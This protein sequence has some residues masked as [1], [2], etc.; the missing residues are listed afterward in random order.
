MRRTSCLRSTPSSTHWSSDEAAIEVSKRLESILIDGHKFF[1]AKQVVIVS[2]KDQPHVQLAGLV[3]HA[4]QICVDVTDR[5]ISLLET[6]DPIA[7]RQLLAIRNFNADS[8]QANIDRS[9]IAAASNIRRSV[10]QNGNG[11]Q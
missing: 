8:A 7:T 6:N 10:R 11:D 4:A 9:R 5:T 1:G 2:L 3:S